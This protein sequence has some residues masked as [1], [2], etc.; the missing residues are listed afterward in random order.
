MKTPGA[1][2]A[3][4]ALLIILQYLAS[5]DEGKLLWPLTPVADSQKHQNGT[6]PKSTVEVKPILYSRDMLGCTGN[7]ANRIG[8]G[9]TLRGAYLHSCTGCWRASDRGEALYWHAGAEGH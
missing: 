6:T 8:P 3:V 7:Q 5:S 1:A 2:K 4:I 9:A